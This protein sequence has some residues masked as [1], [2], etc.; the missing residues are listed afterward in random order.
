MRITI[1]PYFP[2]AAPAGA[3]LAEGLAGLFDCAADLAA[4]A[5]P[6]ARQPPSGQCAARVF[7][8]DL[9]DRRSQRSAAGAVLL[10]VTD[11]DLGAKRMNF[12]FGEADRDA[13]VA[14]VSLHRLGS[15]GG[16][17]AEPGRIIQDRLLKEAVHEC[18]HVADLDHCEDPRCVMH[19]SSAVADT[20]YKGPGFC[21]ACQ[22]KLA[23]YGHGTG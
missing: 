13:R 6:P 17:E 4:F 9:R 7:L 21:A 23:Q 18:G 10:G 11:A 3:R 15:A 5:P 22:K 1:V 8:D 12:V 14:V 16:T 20:D 19:F 2:L